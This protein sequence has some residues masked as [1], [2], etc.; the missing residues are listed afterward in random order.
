MG[1]DV[2]RCFFTALGK[3][4]GTGISADSIFV[5]STAG[6]AGCDISPVMVLRPGIRDLS[7][8]RAAIPVSAL[9][10]YSVVSADAES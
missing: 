2:R 1:A 8:L 6:V 3:S 4:P 10:L 5:H 7:G 9:S